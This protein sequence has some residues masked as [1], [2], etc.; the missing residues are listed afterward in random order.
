MVASGS[1]TMIVGS[2]SGNSAG[3]H[4]YPARDPCALAPGGLSL[5][6]PVGNLIRLADKAESRN[7]SVL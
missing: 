1:R 2:L 6:V 5:V 7:A 3:S 4:N